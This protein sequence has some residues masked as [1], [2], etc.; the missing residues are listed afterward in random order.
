M[1]TPVGSIGAVAAGTGFSILTSLGDSGANPKDEGTGF[2]HMLKNK[3]GLC[4]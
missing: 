3:M 1:F 2:K 4:E